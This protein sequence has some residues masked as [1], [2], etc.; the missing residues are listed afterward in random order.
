[1]AL[2]ALSRRVAAAGEPFRL[3]FRPA[4]LQDELKKLGFHRTDFLQGEQINA[5]YFSGRTDGLKVRGGL[6][7]LMGAWV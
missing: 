7:H 3:F 1:M 2:D 5:R 6:G 4:G